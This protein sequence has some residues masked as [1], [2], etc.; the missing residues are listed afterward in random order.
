VPVLTVGLPDDL[1]LSACLSV[2]SASRSLMGFPLCS[3]FTG[4][5]GHM[6]RAPMLT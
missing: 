5:L 2:D 4:V 6:S 1:P 3:P